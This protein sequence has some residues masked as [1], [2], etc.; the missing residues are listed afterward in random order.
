LLAIAAAPAFGQ[1]PSNAMNCPMM[2]D[3]MQKQMSGMM[4][5]MRAM[6]EDTKDPAAKSRM[7]S[8]HERMRAIMANMQKM[9]GGMMMGTAPN[10]PSGTA[11]A[12]TPSPDQPKE[13]HKEHHPGP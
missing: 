6:M 9:H 13:D 4:T 10:N 3:Q 1:T 11:E 7:Q 5:D 8:M 2:G 12:P